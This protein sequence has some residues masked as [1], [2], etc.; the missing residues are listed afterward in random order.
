[1][2]KPGNPADRR[3]FGRRQTSLHAWISVPGRPRLPCIVH[4]PVDRRRP[5]GAREAVVAAL[6]LPA[7]DRGD[8]V[9]VVVRGSPPQ[10]Q[11][12][13]RA[14]PVGGRD[15]AL[16]PR[17]PRKPLDGRQGRLGGRATAAQLRSTRR[18]RPVHG[19]AKA[20]LDGRPRACC[21]R[22][23]PRPQPAR[24]PRCRRARHD[25]R[26]PAAARRHH[27]RPPRRER[28]ALLYAP[29]AR[30][31]ARSAAPRSSARRRSRP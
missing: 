10:P 16:D 27:R 28:R 18:A 22:L 5:A 2:S 23:A 31:R 29:A 24:Q 11:R 9:R 6:Q 19:F 14:L 30:R 3:Q 4:R 7:H 13:R 20:G 17:R 1:M 12:G 8:A 25:R 21:I 26:H 15:G